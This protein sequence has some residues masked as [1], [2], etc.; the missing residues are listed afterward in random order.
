[1]YS[2]IMSFL[3]QNF[4]VLHLH[5]ILAPSHMTSWEYVFEILLRFYH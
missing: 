4:R 2:G 1:M 3:T 5:M